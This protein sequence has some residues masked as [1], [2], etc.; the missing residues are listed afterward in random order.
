MGVTGSEINKIELRI[1]QKF[2]RLDLRALV[3]FSAHLTA[4]A[5]V[6]LKQLREWK[7]YFQELTISINLF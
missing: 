3:H 4:C 1:F 2:R 7:E 6:D 5:S